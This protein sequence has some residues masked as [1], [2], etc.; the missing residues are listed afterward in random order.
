[1][2]INKQRIHRNELRRR[3]LEQDINQK[4]E[5]KKIDE[6]RVNQNKMKVDLI[7]QNLQRAKQAFN[8]LSPKFFLL[9]R[10]QLECQSSYFY[11]Q[12]NMTVIYLAVIRLIES[13]IY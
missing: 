7:Q 9:D 10:I 8:P 2:I 3:K 13:K 4:I 1:M 11:M 12:R 6:E 5:I